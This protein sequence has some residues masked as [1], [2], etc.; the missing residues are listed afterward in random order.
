[1]EEARGWDV[2]FERGEVSGE[3]SGVGELR[4]QVWSQ[5]EKRSSDR[6]IDAIRDAIEAVYRLYGGFY[7]EAIV[8]APNSAGYQE[9][10]GDS[11]D[12]CY[13]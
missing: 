2:E 10:F 3:S 4:D 6:F 5:R 9:D 8:L 7:G 11:T 1:M 12:I 13:A